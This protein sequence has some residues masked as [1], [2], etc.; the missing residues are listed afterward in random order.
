M[1][2]DNSKTDKKFDKSSVILLIFILHV[3]QTNVYISKASNYS[4]RKTFF[5][6]R[7]KRQAFLI[8]ALHGARYKTGK[9]DYAKK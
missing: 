4:I 8:T 1:F 3:H 7:R 6:A 5:P 9:I 2:I